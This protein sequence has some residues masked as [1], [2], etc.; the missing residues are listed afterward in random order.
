VR[1]DEKNN[2]S[3]WFLLH[4]RFIA[5]MALTPELKLTVDSRDLLHISLSLEENCVETNIKAYLCLTQ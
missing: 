3:R 2:F 4:F 5:S 1:L